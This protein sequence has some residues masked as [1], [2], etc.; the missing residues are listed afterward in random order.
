[1][2]NKM[3]QESGEQLGGRASLNIFYPLPCNRRCSKWELYWHPPH[4]T[5]QRNNEVN[6]NV[7]TT[8]YSHNST[9]R[10]VFS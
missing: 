8:G 4:Q 9:V 5:V 10:V 1:M 6:R 3:G 7:E 2:K